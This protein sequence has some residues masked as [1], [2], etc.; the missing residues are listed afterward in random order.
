MKTYR[1]F[2]NYLKSFPDEKAMQAFFLL[3]RFEGI[4]L[5]VESSH[6]LDYA[7]KHAKIRT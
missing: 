3:S 6:T 1:A 2:D 5:A 7:I 4:I